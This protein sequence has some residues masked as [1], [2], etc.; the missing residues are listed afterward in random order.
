MIVEMEAEN[1]DEESYYLSNSPVRRNGANSNNRNQAHNAKTSA[2]SSNPSSY[3][4]Q[5]GNQ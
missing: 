4:V 2:L 5:A 3:D 1:N